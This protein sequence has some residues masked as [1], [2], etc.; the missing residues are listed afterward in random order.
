MRK[1]CLLMLIIMTLLLTS[2]SSG[3]S[4]MVRDLFKKNERETANERFEALIGAI[5]NQDRVALKAF[6]SEKSLKE[7]Q[8]I[9]ETITALFDYFRGDML[10]YNDWGSLGSIGGMNEDGTG[11]YWKCLYATYDVETTQ[12]KYRF[13]MEYMLL[14]T[15]DAD[16]VGIRSLYIIRLADDTDPQ[17]AYR[18]DEKYTPGININKTSRIPHWNV[19]L[20]NSVKRPGCCPESLFLPSDSLPRLTVTSG[21][22]AAPTPMTRTTG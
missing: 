9:E 4:N 18:G 8:N 16:N 13:A 11:R 7:S 17:F 1:V 12:D 14:D 6:F 19:F 20:Q 5:Q 21:Q 2:C 10:S 15:A 22:Q 3:D